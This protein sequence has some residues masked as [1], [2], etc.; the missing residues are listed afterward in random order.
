MVSDDF[1]SG[2]DQVDKAIYTTGNVYM[3]FETD[4]WAVMTGK[5]TFET[6]HLFNSVHDYVTNGS[7]I[8]LK[9]DDLNGWRGA[10]LAACMWCLGFGKGE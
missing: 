7:C 1:D 6:L 2:F 3:G 10:E 5:E 9:V 8:T 4:R